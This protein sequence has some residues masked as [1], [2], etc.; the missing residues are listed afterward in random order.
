LIRKI[1]V[2]CCGPEGEHYSR[3]FDSDHWRVVE[4]VLE[5]SNEGSA[6]ILFAKHEWVS[7]EVIR[8]IAN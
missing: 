5:L 6:F 2:T 1:R 8:E 4:G 7:A 3:D